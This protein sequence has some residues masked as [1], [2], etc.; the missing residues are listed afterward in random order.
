MAVLILFCATIIILCLIGTRLSHKIGIP[1][2]LLFMGLGMLFG[3]D[4]LFKIPFDNYQFAE[5]LCS[6]A[7]IFIM[8]YGG[9]G[10]NW[11]AAKPVAAKACLLSSVGVILTAL[12][13]GL[14]CHIVLRFDFLESMLIGAV[15][16]ST[17]AASVFSILRSKKLNLKENSA[18]LLEIESGS[19]DP[20]SYMLTVII[21]TMMQ[22]DSSASSI[23]YLVF[24]QVVYG[25]VFGVLIALAALWILHRFSFSQGGMDTIFVLAVALLS[26]AIPSVLN[27]NGYLSVYITGIIIGNAKVKNKTSLVHFFDGVTGLMQIIV[28]FLLGLLA[29]P[30]S[31]PQIVLPALAIALFLTF[32]ARPAVVFGL[33]L[34]THSSLRQKLLVSWA[35]LRGAS[36][37]V[38]AI[39]ATISPAYTKS[40]VFHVA[41]CIVLLSITFQGTLLPWVA[42]KLHMVDATGDVRRTFN[43]YQEESK[44]H[45]IKS[46]IPSSHPWVDKPLRDIS[47]PPNTLLVLILRRGETL[48]PSGNTVIE[49]DD[50]AIISAAPFEDN[51]DL[52]LTEVLADEGS[53]WVGKKI[54]ELPLD[55]H[56]L[57]IFIK[58]RDKTIIPKG[59]TMICKNDIIICM[60]K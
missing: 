1:A 27:G 34:P 6:I 11:N 60:S 22:G 46:Q 39:M 2:L 25:A 13:T 58:R 16:S 52:S 3:S 53:T 36:A 24:A 51:P 23:F 44:L 29:F 35:G 14:F 28:F 8:F 21:L 20:F 19:N 7:L 57:V 15:I 59:T 49:A 33:L 55:E 56:H 18:S 48:I 50:T 32:I 12:L 43:D 40:D 45:F 54:S 31:L 42:Q 37:I 38:F 47:L 4:G 9:F 41:F 5:Q 10:T 30:S 17:D 26:Y